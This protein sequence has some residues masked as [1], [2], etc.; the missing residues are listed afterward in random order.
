M[1]VSEANQFSK[2]GTLRV[3][4]IR[5]YLHVNGFCQSTEPL[6]W[7]CMCAYG[8]FNGI[9]KA[10]V[11]CSSTTNFKNF[12]YYFKNILLLYFCLWIGNSGRDLHGHTKI[13]A[14]LRYKMQVINSLLREPCYLNT[15]VS[16]LFGFISV[17]CISTWKTVSW[18]MVVY[19]RHIT[20]VAQ[21]YVHVFG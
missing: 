4:N 16:L 3:G 6:V 5:G 15:Y 8:M 9:C 12:N 7:L 17:G 13:Y 19:G 11:P 2:V 18:Q 21:A 1:H 14:S 10:R 20:C